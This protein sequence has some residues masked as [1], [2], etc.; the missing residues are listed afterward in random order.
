MFFEK[1]K[2]NLKKA[3][4]KIGLFKIIRVTGA[5]HQ[6]AVPIKEIATYYNGREIKRE[7]L[8]EELVEEVVR[9]EIPFKV[10][11][12]VPKEFEKEPSQ[13]II[14]GRLE[15]PRAGIIEE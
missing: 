14:L 7:P 15:L 11:E 4:E 8:T 12:W 9:K 6:F 2:F 10:I 3:Y 5:G 13:R 1:K